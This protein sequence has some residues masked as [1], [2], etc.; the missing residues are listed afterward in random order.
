M[1]GDLSDR[2]Q[3]IGLN[4]SLADAWSLDVSTGLSNTVMGQN[5]R[6]KTVA[7]NYLFHP[8]SSVSLIWSD[9]SSDALASPNVVAVSP[10]Q[11]DS[12]VELGLRWLF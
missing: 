5:Q 7:L 4:W 1:L 8:R 10:A 6:Q 2:S 9:N 12:S 11:S 3:T